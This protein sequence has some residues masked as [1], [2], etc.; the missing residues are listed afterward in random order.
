MGDAI[1]PDACK[2]EWITLTMPYSQPEPPQ[3]GWIES[4][5]RQWGEPLRWAITNVSEQG[6]E[7]EAVVLRMM[8][9]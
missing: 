7:I 9:P 4:T 8:D 6:L 3:P 5:L 1:V 2:I